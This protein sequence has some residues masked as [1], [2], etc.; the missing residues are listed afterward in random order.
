MKIHQQRTT[1]VSRALIGLTLGLM[2]C[3]LGGCATSEA[4]RIE[5]HN[6][7]LPSVDESE[8]AVGTQPEEDGYVPATGGEVLLQVQQQGKQN[9]SFG[10]LDYEHVSWKIE[11]MQSAA[12]SISL[13]YSGESGPSARSEGKDCASGDT[14][15]R[16]PLLVAD[17]TVSL[18]DT[19]EGMGVF[20]PSRAG[21]ADITVDVPRG[22]SYLLT[23]YI[24]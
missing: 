22:I 18:E 20:V 11:C 15:Y 7:Q 9:F 1:P 19:G 24:E 23:V 17:R 21:A 12:Y 3:S 2:A 13:K 8:P 4:A 16:S 6:A 5:A 10:S 14:L